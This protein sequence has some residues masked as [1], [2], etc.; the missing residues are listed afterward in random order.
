[1]RI[2]DKALHKA[3]SAFIKAHRAIA[4]LG[5]KMNEA[6]DE[7][8]SAARHVYFM[9][10]MPAG[11]KSIDFQCKAG[12]ARVT[13]SDTFREFGESD[14]LKHVLG[15]HYADAVIDK[16]NL[17][18]DVNLIAKGRRADFIRRLQALAAEFGH[19][20][21]VE[22]DSVYAIN[23]EWA[24]SRRDLIPCFENIRIEEKLKL[25]RVSVAV[26]K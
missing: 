12:A 6:K 20:E 2:K 14:S 13:F 26:A 16:F 23:P 9:G 11:E 17:A 1:M 19:R 3:A 5:V 10:D 4:K 25:Q 22:V 15:A 21:A 7:L 8:I 24:E 18:V